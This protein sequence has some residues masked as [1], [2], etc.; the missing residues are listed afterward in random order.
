MLRETKSKL[1]K[2]ATEIRTL[3]NQ[4]PLKN[5]GDKKLWIIDS[6]LC[7]LKYHFR[8]I[9]IAYCELRGRSRVQIEKP[10]EFNKPN[11]SYIDKIKK[12]ILDKYEAEQAIRACA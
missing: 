3:K 2:I 7:Q 6:D 10:S 11:Q 4:R 5:R 9:H 1:K 8:H 12:E